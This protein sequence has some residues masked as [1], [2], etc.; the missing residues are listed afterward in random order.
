MNL[1]AKI[2]GT[3]TIHVVWVSYMKVHVRFQGIPMKLTW[4]DLTPRWSFNISSFWMIA[5]APGFSRIFQLAMVYSCYIIPTDAYNITIKSPIKSH[6]APPLDPIFNYNKIMKNPINPTTIRSHKII[7]KSH[8]LAG[9]IHSTPIRSH[10]DFGCSFDTPP[11]AFSRFNLISPESLSY[12]YHHNSCTSQRTA[13]TLPTSGVSQ[14]TGLSY[15]HDIPM[16]PKQKYSHNYIPIDIPI[17]ILWLVVEPYPSEKYGFV[18]WDDDYSQYM[19]SHKIHVPNHH[20]FPRFSGHGL[21]GSWSEAL[22]HTFRHRKCQGPLVSPTSTHTSAMLSQLVAPVTSLYL[23]GTTLQSQ[24]TTNAQRQPSWLDTSKSK[25]MGQNFECFLLLHGT[26]PIPLHGLSVSRRISSN[27]WTICIEVKKD[28]VQGW[29]RVL[30][31]GP[32][33]SYLTWSVLGI[34]R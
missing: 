22:D 17:E 2:W 15:S 19:E 12:R 27:V 30:S 26:T 34:P 16:F 23:A 18:S 9:W 13:V 33:S 3:W 28:V 10:D 11:G 24:R 31:P 25:P 21:L 1:T 5:M 14:N 32:T 29:C 7:I 4:A 6:N 20:A 8:K